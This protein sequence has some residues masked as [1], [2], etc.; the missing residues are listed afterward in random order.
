MNSL[1]GLA[2]AVV[3]S[4]GLAV[5]HVELLSISEIT[6]SQNCKGQ[7]VAFNCKD[8]AEIINTVGNSTGVATRA[9]CS[10]AM[11]NNDL[12]ASMGRKLSGHN[13]TCITRKS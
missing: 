10:A 12:D 6:G 4:L 11:Y 3:H 9:P 7:M 2:V 13:V 8:R 5:G 1:R